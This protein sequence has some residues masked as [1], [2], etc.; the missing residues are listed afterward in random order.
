MTPALV[1]QLVGVKVLRE[2]AAAAPTAVPNVAS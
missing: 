1:E 2:Q